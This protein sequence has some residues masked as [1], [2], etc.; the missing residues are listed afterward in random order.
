MYLVL[1]GDNSKPLMTYIAPGMEGR[2]YRITSLSF[3]PHG[4]DILVSYSSEH[5]YLFGV[6]VLSYF[7]ISLINKL[8]KPAY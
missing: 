4:E 6:Q 8:T 3:S 7:F 5:L 1:D 2:S